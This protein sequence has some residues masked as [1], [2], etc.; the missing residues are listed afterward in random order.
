MTI[1]DKVHGE[2]VFGRRTRVLARHL[3]QLIPEHCSVLDVGCGDGLIDQLVLNQ[4]SDIA[5]EG[6]DVLIRPHTHIPVQKFDGVQMPVADKSVDIVMFVDVLHHTDDAL[7]LLRDAAR[8][9]R[10][11]VIIKDHLRNGFLA[12]PTLRFMDWVGNE[13]HNVRLPY[14]YWSQ[15]QWDDAF[16][17]VG[18]HREDWRTSLDIYPPGA[19]WMFGRS[20]HFMTRLS[21]P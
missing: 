2:Y 4:R 9:A 6:I 1:I 17:A 7:A 21:V 20:L 19:N 13:R 8:V 12:G 11:G 5:I 18:L 10:R 3:T 15:A 16:S 14:N